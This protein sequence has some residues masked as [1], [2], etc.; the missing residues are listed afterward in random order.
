VRDS[1]H[2]PRLAQHLFTCDLP[3]RQE[4]S[5]PFIVTTTQLPGRSVVAVSGELDLATC[6]ELRVALD[7]ALRDESD[8]SVGVDL[9]ELSFCDSSGL[10]VLLQASRQAAMRRIE[11][12]MTRPPQPAWRAFEIS[13]L[14]SV[15]PFVDD[16]ALDAVATQRAG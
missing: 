6:E 16:A 13:A 11:L 15:L 9:R 14:D 4:D 1:R 8:A 2:V 3:E 5:M 7:D 12:V 10:K